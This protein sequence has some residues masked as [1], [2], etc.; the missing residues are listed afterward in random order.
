MR[1]IFALWLILV[2][3]PLVAAEPLAP[4][5][6]KQ[7]AEP[8]VGQRWDVPLGVAGPS[9]P[10]LV[11]G[12]RTSWGEYQKP[13]P[14][15]VLAW[16]AANRVWENQF[17]LGKNWGPLTGPAQ[18]PGWKDEHF[19][20]RDSEGNTRPNWSVYGTFSLGQKYDFDP[21]TKKFYFFAHGKTFAY[22]PAART[23]E[24]RQPPTNPT[25][26]LG[27]IL[28]WSSMC[29]DSHRQRFVLFGGGNIP[30]ERGDPGTWVYS[31]REN[32][33]SQLKL[34]RQPT[35]RANSRLAYDPIA[36]KI[37]LF[38]GDQLQILLSDTWT[39]D[40][41]ADR[42]EQCYPLLGPS[43][44]GGHALLWLPTA[45]RL[46]LLGGY[47]Y[48]ST[49]EYVASL[50]KSPPLEAWLFD[51]NTQAWQLVKRWEPK[52]SPTSPSNFFLSASVQPGRDHDL[53]T[54]L[55]DGTWQCEL[56]AIEDD[57]G[58]STW[59]VL[60]GEYEIR[61]DSYDPA[62]YQKDVPAAEPE[63]VAAELR[64]LPMNRWV[65]RP[66]PK[67]PGMNMDWGSAV[68]APELDQII[69]FSGGHSAY[70]GTA[71]QVYDVKTDRYSIPFAPELPLEFVYSNDQVDGEWS[72]GGN[73]WMTGHTYK[74]T[75]YDSRLKCLVFA[76]HDNTYFF[77]SVTGKW[78]R[79]PEQNPYRADFYNV[80]L[81]S[82]PQGVVAWGDR[83][84]GGDAGLWRLDAKERVWRPLTLRGSLPDKSP[85]QHGMAYDSKRDR[86]LFFSGTDQNKG[87]VAAY[88]LASGEAR[89]LNANGKTFAAVPSRETVY[90]PDADAV[91]LGARASVG[92]KHPWLLYD[93]ASN[94]WRGLELLGDDPIGKGTADRTFNNSMGLMYDPHRKL[95][96]AVGQYSHVH[97]LRLDSSASRPLGAKGR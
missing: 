59:G 78:S 65:L 47:S 48:S 4:N 22:D 14:Y 70:S 37:V 67:R 82:T 33:W 39:F 63:R 88:D 16:N 93:C 60:P 12:G 17:P 8:L 76:P 44:R 32:T 10:L 83:R 74:S 41:V 94:S 26:E 84:D 46:L 43:P 64:D 55:A 49:T 81:C 85:D 36:K 90:L 92:D 42:W 29:Y 40:V 54:V 61:T 72:F 9:G 79:G 6:W 97:V 68:F 87:D 62:W 24:D 75:G 21:D 66:T 57:E 52:E 71:P 91:L 50:Y 73:P 13:R 86:L 28:L 23:W 77:D 11:L 15:D 96:W 20:F 27:G 45:K 58:T 1:L 7:V 35:P 30:T 89:W 19:D 2:A 95:V 34:D 51:T 56:Q 80:T 18:A 31:P 38:G 69:R 3:L 5:S 53:V 25:G